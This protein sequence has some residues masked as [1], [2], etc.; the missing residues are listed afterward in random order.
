MSEIKSV[1]MV[2]ALHK[3]YLIHRYWKLKQSMVGTECNYDETYQHIRAD[4]SK[5]AL[6]QAPNKNLCI[7]IHQAQNTLCTIR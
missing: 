2:P 4:V 3:A 7:K 6:V 1:P 5:E